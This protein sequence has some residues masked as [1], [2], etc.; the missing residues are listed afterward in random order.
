MPGVRNHRPGLRN[1]PRPG[2]GDEQ[3]DHVDEPVEHPE[4]DAREVPVA[5]QPEV[6]AARL[7]HPGRPGL[8]LFSGNPRAFGM[9]HAAR[10]L[11]P[12]GARDAVVIPVEPRVGGEDLDPGANHEAHQEE[13]DPVN[14]EGPAHALT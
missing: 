3:P 4:A 1:E 12:L 13:V 10:E 2:A 9:D 11:D 5:A 6:I 8:F 14:M 7:G